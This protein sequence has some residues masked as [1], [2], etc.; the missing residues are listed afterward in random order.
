MSP[1]FLLPKAPFP[2]SSP[3]LAQ[4]P[5][6]FLASHCAAVFLAGLASYITLLFQWPLSYLW[7]FCQS[8]LE[9]QCF[10]PAQASPRRHSHTHPAHF[11]PLH[12][13]PAGAGKLVVIDS[14]HFRL[15]GLNDQVRLGGCW[16]QEGSIAAAVA[17]DGLRT[18]SPV[19]LSISRRTLEAVLVAG[20]APHVVVG[21]T[22]VAA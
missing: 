4:N 22:E 15:C 5:L 17:M 16:G 9:V 20:F 1:L 14:W 8:L 10:D 13:S 11:S 2:A 6:P 3:F 18:G 21:G 7:P 12:P 19:F